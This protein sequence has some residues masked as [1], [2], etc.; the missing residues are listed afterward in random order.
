MSGAGG[1]L[2]MARGASMTMDK[3]VDPAAPLPS[4]ADEGDSDLEDAPE[5]TVR[6]ELEPRAI[7]QALAAPSLQVC[8]C[9]RTGLAWMHDLWPLHTCQIRSSGSMLDLCV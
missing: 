2:P 1:G 7:E 4:P 5:G 6:F 9:V 3:H 8:L